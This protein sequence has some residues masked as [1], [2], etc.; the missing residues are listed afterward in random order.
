M[1]KLGVPVD[2][3]EAAVLERRRNAALQ[4][5]SRIFDCKIRTIGIDKDALDIQVNNRKIQKE[6]EKRRHELYGNCQTEGGIVWIVQ[7]TPRP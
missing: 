2:R 4:R 5:Q 7:K 1:Y 3:K 6:T